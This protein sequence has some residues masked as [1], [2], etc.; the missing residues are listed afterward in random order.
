MTGFT[1]GSHPFHFATNNTNGI[2][3]ETN[4]SS[5]DILS[6]ALSL[7]TPSVNPTSGYV[8]TDFNFTVNYA[9]PANLQPVNITVIISS[10]GTFD[11]VEVDPLDSDYTDGKDYY[12]NISGFTIRTY[13]FHFEA[14]DSIG[15]SV[16]SET[17]Q[18]N[19]LN[20]A[21]IFSLPQVAPNSGN[22]SSGFNFSVIYGDLD[23]KAPNKISVNITGYGVYDLIEVDP[24]DTDYSDGKEYYY[25]AT[26]FTV[27][28]FTFHFAAND[29]QGAWVETGLLGFN[30]TNR[31]PSLTIALVNPSLGYLNSDFNFTVIYIDL[32]DHAPGRITVNISGVGIYDLIEYDVLDLN[33]FDG[34]QYYLNTSG[35]SLG[36]YIFHF[37]A[38]DSVGFWVESS[39]FGFDVVNRVPTL[40][41]PQV[42]P[43]LGYLASDF[44]FTV[45]YTDL[46][47]Q[48]PGK[49]SVN[50][51]GLGVYDL[52]ESNPLDL[53][54]SDG[55]EYYLD[56]TGFSLG[57]YT[58]H[59]AAND[60][61]GY[62]VE[63]GNFGFDVIN[64]L[65]TLTIPQVS[66]ILGYLATNFN[67]TVMYTD[68][69]DQ[70][71]GRI[72]VNISGAGIFDLIESNPLDLD[73]SDGKGYYLNTTGFVLGSF[74]LHFAAN[75]SIGY[76]VETSNLGFDVINRPPSLASPLVD[77]VIGYVGSGFNF[78]VIYTDLDNQ[79][80]SNIL[81]NISG[82]GSYSLTESDSSDVDFTNGKSYY[83]NTSGI[84]LGLYSFNLAV[85]DTPGDWVESNLLQ[86]DV[87]NRVPTLSFGGVDPITG[88]FNSWFNFTVTYLDPDG[89]PPNFVVVNISGV[90]SYV[91]YEIDPLDTDYSDGK[92]YYY[93]ISNLPVG[94]HS[95][96][97]A[98]ND[99]Q[100]FWA[101]ET[102][103][104]TNL[105][106]LPI[107]A[108][109]LISDIIIEYS[110]DF[111]I[112]ATL[113]DNK[114]QAISGEFVSIYI[115]F[116]RNG[117][118]EPTELLGNNQTDSNGSIVI[119]YTDN[120]IPG[121]WKYWAIYNGSINYLV[122]DAE[123]EITIDPKPASLLA[124]SNDVETGE[125][126]DL[127][128]LLIDFD[129]N[130]IEGENVAFYI[131]FKQ[132]GFYEVSELIST[133]LT[134]SEGVAVISYL[135][136]LAPGDYGF[137]A[138]YIGSGNYS[139]N[140]ID[141]LL[142]VHNSTDGPPMILIPVP[143]QTK[144]EDSPAWTLD[145]T[146]Y[147]DDL[148]DS[149]SDLNWYL[150]GID[151][152]LYTI[153][154]YNSSNDE[155][156]FIPHP[157]AF[158]NDE[159]TLWLSDSSGNLVSQTLWINITS[160][161]D[162]PFFKPL[163]P[164]LVVHFD[165]PITF[166][167]TFYV[168]DV[169]TPIDDLILSTSQPTVD[170]GDGYAEVNGLTVT[171]QY[172]ETRV[173]DNILVT[174]K[175]SDGTD[176]AN[177]AILVNVSTDWVPKLIAKLPNIVIKENSTL[178]NAFDLDDHFSDKD[179]N[180]LFFSSGFFHIQVN[181]NENNTVDIT[182]FGDWTGEEYVTFRAVD[183]VGAL[184]EDTIKVTVIPVN[185]GPEISDVPDLVVHYDYSYAFDLS[186]YIKDS[187][188]QTI[189]LKISSSELTDYIWVQSGNNLGIVINYPE[190]FNGMTIPVTIYVTDGYEIDSQEIQISVTDDFPPELVSKLPDVFF[191]EDA[192]ILGAFSLSD[193]FF[194]FDGD[195]LFYTKG[196]QLINVTINPD[197]SVDFSA[198]LNWFGSEMVTF[199]ATDSEGA[200]AE[201]S[202]LV[203]VIPVNDA[204]KID[205]IPKQERDRSDEWT[206]DVSQFI[207]DVDNDI[208]DLIISVLSDFGT[209]YVRIVGNV[210]I[211]QYPDDIYED[212]VT[213]TVSDG[214]LETTKSFIVTIQ[215]PEPAIPSI[216]EMIP[217]IWVLAALAASLLGI[218]VFFRRHSRF[219]VYEVFLIH[220]KGLPLAHASQKESS[221]LEEVVVSGMFTAVQDF[222]ND[223]FMG[224]TDD[225]EW[226]LDEM[227]FG[228]N[229][230]LIERQENLFLAVIFGGNGDKLRIRVKR[231]L[232]EINTEFSSVL[233]D[234]D[235]DMSKLKGLRAMT[236][237]LLSKKPEKKGKKKK[238]VK[239]EPKITE[240]EEGI[241]APV[242]SHEQRD[243]TPESVELLD[244]AIAEA[245][246]LVYETDMHVSPEMASK[247]PKGPEGSEIAVQNMDHQDCPVCGADYKASDM[248][249]T[250][251]G[252]E[253]GRLK[254]MID[255]LQV[256]IPKCPSC[257]TALEKGASICAVCG[258]D[259]RGTKKKIAVF[260]CPECGGSVEQN[261][262][263]CS[264]CGVEF[265]E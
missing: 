204:P 203:V 217:W 96:H 43:T 56:I 110:D 68:L 179:H 50:I 61:I 200:I 64:R 18:F 127:S 176:F 8:D 170:R 115:D 246:A 258:Y 51:S 39:N 134:S 249:C 245:E 15:N 143:H 21:P 11:L 52:I 209:G 142:T 33:Y 223:A 104:I 253:F 247:I 37:A 197:L 3:V 228:E 165:D 77:P 123:A 128:A 148:E 240:K 44:N 147:E 100:G 107:D 94:S 2:W 35:F 186:P 53:D 187:D 101:N 199:R 133:S 195:A 1:F 205:N 103:E 111:Q 27:G 193:Y 74:T 260:E 17:N 28:S 221:E 25:N 73:F 14:N 262:R 244:H 190:L 210:I 19:I 151:T 178:Y 183:P 76:W 93:N 114:I 20:R 135:V 75:D 265:I 216:W 86:F 87:I 155:I 254:K 208:S 95:F 169:E 130:Q 226:E 153:T 194:D 105:E 109:I 158:G 248:S 171:F 10:Y 22:I 162:P 161:N 236:M 238:K 38:N 13:S 6:S 92:L 99:S 81:V 185:D 16:V 145:L 167:Y 140:E 211:F 121:I 67:F 157:D 102:P 139:V 141:G 152:S 72:V 202:V 89:D 117:I 181:I 62:W 7:T 46:D 172:P 4:S 163:P 90:G 189:D 220:D 85:S 263:F 112:T 243:L 36:S 256:E 29:S 71:P 212:I 255:D 125:L 58:F 159:T 5:F 231:L 32:D 241:Q 168:H 124:V 188:N 78:T 23:N 215:R 106:V 132:D 235:G 126:V 207:T 63:T 206:L 116:N 261:A 180:T 192:Q 26:G 49:I 196:N 12:I 97:F 191:S 264:Q 54:F 218:F 66:P 177:T 82:L 83:F 131:D 174:L 233:N 234:W 182:S 59:F 252:T 237:K 173:G 144:T 80:P 251:C 31:A 136:N 91:L 229:K 164:N 137:R 84:P 88:Y 120:I 113:L 250:I 69:D 198:P 239:P 149:G 57:S 242:T 48:A 213:V 60:S 42:N 98:A 214:E 65:P 259:S 156:T 119:D 138:K 232:D 225:D 118:Y 108:S 219:W 150:T 201:D 34:K 230:I 160:V 9:S 184:V 166:D 45:I 70:A 79:A 224:K 47:N 129:S 122:A 24:L 222:I 227:K 55:K 154:G 40:T 30:V 175:I 257:S 146:E 41:L